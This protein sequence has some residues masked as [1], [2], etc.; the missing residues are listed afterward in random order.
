VRAK[1]SKLAIVDRLLPLLEAYGASRARQS[2]IR[3][4]MKAAACTHPDRVVAMP[5]LLDESRTV[6]CFDAEHGRTPWCDACRQHD[7]AFT[8]LM[9]ERAANKKRFLRIEKLA[10]AYAEPEAE[11]PPEPKELLELMHSLQEEAV[12]VETTVVR[13]G[14]NEEAHR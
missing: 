2:I 8:R 6:P 3:K 12:V 1:A 5:S 7:Q 14:D 4:E 10:V 9:A 11:V 13:D